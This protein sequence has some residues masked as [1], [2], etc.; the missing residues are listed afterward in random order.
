M[1]W[2]VL[3]NADKES[4]LTKR[5][6]TYRTS[7]GVILPDVVGRVTVPVHTAGMRLICK[8]IVKSV[9]CNKNVSFA[10]CLSV[11]ESADQPSIPRFWQ[12]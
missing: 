9:G 7:V 11:M 3:A 1:A 2:F 12:S 5:G 4:I 10:M 8:K 6:T